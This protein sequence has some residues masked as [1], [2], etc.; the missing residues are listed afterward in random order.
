MPNRSTTKPA[1]DALAKVEGSTTLERV[2]NFLST[3]R[4]VEEDPTETMLAAILESEHPLDW[5]RVFT[6]RSFKDSEAARIR[7]NAYRPAE[8]QFGGELKWF[9]VLDVTDLKS[10]ERGVMT[11]GSVMSVAQIINAERRVGLP[12]DVEIVR[13]ATPTKNGFHPFHLRYLGGATAPLGDPGA[14]VSEQ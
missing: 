1:L 2:N 7:I 3:V 10:G 14:V 8:S 5:E 6:S 11:C 4:T 13:K 9:L 12:V